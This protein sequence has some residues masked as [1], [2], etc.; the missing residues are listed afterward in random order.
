MSKI[1]KD[2]TYDGCHLLLDC[3][4]RIF[5]T[6]QYE[7]LPE[8]EEQIS[9]ENENYYDAQEELHNV[10][11]DV[12]NEAYFDAQEQPISDHQQ[13]KFS[14]EK[15]KDEHQLLQ[16]NHQLLQVNHE[17]LELDHQN[18]EKLANEYLKRLHLQGKICEKNCVLCTILWTCQ[19]MLGFNLCGPQLLLIMS[20]HAKKTVME[21]DLA[22]QHHI[23][24]FLQCEVLLQDG[25][26]WFPKKGSKERE[27][28]IKKAWKKLMSI[29]KGVCL[30][31]IKKVVIGHCI[32]CDL[33]TRPK[34]DT[35]MFHDPQKE[36][37]GEWALKD[38]VK[39]LDDSDAIGL[40]LF[41]VDLAK[42]KDIIENNIKIVHFTDGSHQDKKSVPIVV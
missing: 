16:R 14:Y 33:N 36:E 12:D 13:L 5:A 34:P 29:G 21:K 17:Q 27:N 41:P 42:L 3:L 26:F 6:N 31:G 24:I 9:V 15:L 37:E 22:C 39:Y 23:N 38:F 35:V 1:T 30:L 10:Q 2:L 4:N 18:Q 28:A 20:F 19:N 7:Q 25:D 8:D 40:L 11:E 32:L